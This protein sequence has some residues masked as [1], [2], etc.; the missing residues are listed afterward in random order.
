MRCAAPSARR[1]AT[2]G[3]PPMTAPRRSAWTLGGLLLGLLLSFVALGL[4]WAGLPWT[5][6]AGMALPFALAGFVVRRRG[7]A[8]WAVAAGALPMA[9]LFVQ[10]RDAAGSHA[11]PVA[12]ALG[13]LVAGGVGAWA[14]GRR[15]ASPAG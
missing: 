7:G 9:A 6:Q 3:L 11:L 10:F 1:A 13:W 14:A 2:E 5:A 12:L 4:L 8:V 15:G